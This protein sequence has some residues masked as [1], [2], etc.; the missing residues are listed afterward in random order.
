MVTFITK[1]VPQISLYAQHWFI[2]SKILDVLKI[3]NDA[4]YTLSDVYYPTS[5]LYIKEC[6]N[7]AGLFEQ[8]M[9]D[10]ELQLTIHAMKS[11]WLNCY[12]Y[13]LPI[14]LIASIFNPHVK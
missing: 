13:I 4:T 9:M 6:V 1:N 3:F 8:H 11:K 10:N 2:C 14:Y 5:H 12:L 7:V